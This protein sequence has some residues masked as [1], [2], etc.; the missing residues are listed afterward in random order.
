MPK[1]TAKHVQ[2]YMSAMLFGSDRIIPLWN[3]SPSIKTNPQTWNR[4]VYIGDVGIFNEQGAF[5]TLFNIFLSAEENVAHGHTPPHGFIRYKK[6]LQQIKIDFQD[7]VLTPSKTLRSIGLTSNSPDGGY[8]TP[9]SYSNFAT[10]NGLIELLTV[11]KLA[12][13]FMSVPENAPPFI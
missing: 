5:D 11:V 2:I 4:H 8:G 13:R 3:P 10:H 12:H 6:N 7:V 1:H 9:Y